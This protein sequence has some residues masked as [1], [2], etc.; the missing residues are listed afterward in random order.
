MLW[1]PE[2]CLKKCLAFYWYIQQ[3]LKYIWKCV[4]YFMDVVKTSKRRLC[5]K[6]L[7]QQPFEHIGNRSSIHDILLI[8][9]LRLLHR[10][11]SE[12]RR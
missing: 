11:N 9:F 5:I 4:L 3:S 7:K 8:F 10:S 6:Y 2:K 12:M 1:M